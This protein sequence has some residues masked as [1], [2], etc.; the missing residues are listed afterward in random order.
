MMQS[1]YKVLAS[2]NSQ[3]FENMSARSTSKTLQHEQYPGHK[4]LSQ[5]KMGHS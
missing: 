5:M 4:I 1:A 3:G 2:L